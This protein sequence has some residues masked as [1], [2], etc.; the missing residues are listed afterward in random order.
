[1]GAT[2]SLGVLRFGTLFRDFLVDALVELGDELFGVVEGGVEA[3]DGFF[4]E[5]IAMHT[6]E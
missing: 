2:N 5:G 3:V 4:V 1:M 6:A